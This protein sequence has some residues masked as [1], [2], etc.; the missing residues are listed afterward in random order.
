[1][2]TMGSRVLICVTL[3]MVGVVVST[4]AAAQRGGGGHG[5]GGHGGGG[6]GGGGRGGYRGG[7]G[8]RGGGIG[9]WGPGLGLGLGWDAAYPYYYG[10]PYGFPV[11]PDDDYA[12]TA[13]A[14]VIGSGAAPTPN[15][16]YCESAKDYY[17]RVSQC[18]ESW[19]LVP[20]VP[21]GPAQ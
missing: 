15:W 14:P 11:Y 18:P 5:G 20:A 2:K 6:H 17:P 13:P 10:D 21:S 1:M 8:W 19:R 9:W 4:P 16:Y 12:N 7:G 3:L